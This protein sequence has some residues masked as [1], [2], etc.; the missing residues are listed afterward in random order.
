MAEPKISA[1]QVKEL[2][3]KTG[4]GMMDCKRAL[5][6]AGG[7]AENA[8]ILLKEQGL[9]T[10]KKRQER[11]AAQGVIESY[12]HIGGQIGSLVEVNCETDFVAR[13]SEFLG[14]AHQI[15]LH[16]AAC[17]PLYIDKDSVPQELIASRKEEYRNECSVG[18]KPEKVWDDIIGGML[19]KHY[20]DICLLEQPFVKDPS[21]SVAELLAQVSAK[22]GEKI[23][24]RR[25]SRFQ[26][27]EKQE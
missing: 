24:I 11:T 26:V 3:A 22:V 18:G 21:I 13:N 20:Q 15:A 10:V 16:V 12:I 4:A 27:G 19:E 8:M 7:D 6:D 5:A 1:Q 2:R 14:F 25:F 23:E 17:N 9:A